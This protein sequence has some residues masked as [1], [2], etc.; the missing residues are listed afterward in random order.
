VVKIDKQTLNSICPYFTMFPLEFPLQILKNYGQA[1]Q[2]VVDPFCGRGT[3]NYAARLAGLNTIGIDSNPVAIAITEAKLIH[4]TPAKIVE[5]AKEILEETHVPNDLPEGEFWELAYHPNVL[6]Q[7]CRIREGLLAN[8]LSPERKALKGIMLGGLHGHVMKTTESYFSNQCQRT[9]SPKP[10]YAVRFWKTRN[11]RPP[12]IDVIGVIRKRAE[13]FYTFVPEIV[14]SRAILNDSRVSGLYE[15]D[16]QDILVD[17][18]ITSPPYYGM[19]SYLPD[20]WLR[21]WFVGNSADVNYDKSRQLK[22]TGQDFF[23][24]ELSQVWQNLRT[25]AHEETKMVVRFGGLPSVKSDPLPLLSKSFEN[26]GWAIRE[27]QSA[28][29]STNGQRQ[30]YQQAKKQNPPVEEFDVWVEPV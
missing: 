18:I 27:S 14:E 19:K 5:I 4:T 13:R 11:L 24:R 30:A 15:Q 28:G 22:H 3:T 17:W 8:S 26:T 10:A 2:M 6:N 29:F 9:Y 12:L 20:Q 1:G 21:L 16:L 25:L 7:I 23:A